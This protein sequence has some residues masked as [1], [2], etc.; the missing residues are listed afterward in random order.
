[1]RQGGPGGKK[2]VDI[3]LKDINETYDRMEKRVIEMNAETAARRE[4]GEGEE[5]IQLVAEGDATIAFN[6]PDGPP[7]ET[8]TLEGEGTEGMDPVEV[9][10]YLM[11]RWEIFE[12]LSE[13]MK[14]AVRAETLEGVN[15]VLAKMGLDDAEAAVSAISDLWF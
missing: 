5:Q 6:V 12:E 2:A 11:R 3:F 7:P 4:S 10:K 15:K 13:E 14:A 8:I 9:R 1:M